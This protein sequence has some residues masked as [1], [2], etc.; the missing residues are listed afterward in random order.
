M[1]NC[2]DCKEKEKGKTFNS[3]DVVVAEENLDTTDVLA[4]TI[5]NWSDEWIL[6]SGCS[7]HMSPNRNWF[8]TYQLIDCGKILMGNDVACKVIGIDI[9]QIKMHG[10]IIRTLID[11]RHVP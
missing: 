9:I 3:S 4:I 2:P 5:T 11:V 8:S 7:Y 6:D 1:K 10:A